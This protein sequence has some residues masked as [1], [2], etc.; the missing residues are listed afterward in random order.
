[1]KRILVICTHNSARSQMAEAW[2]RTYTKEL[3]LNAEISSAGTSKTFVKPNAIKVMEEVGIDMSR[4]SS[5][6]LDEL[7]DKQNFYLVI[8]VCDKAKELCPVFPYDCKR[9]HLAFE[10]PSGK[11]LVVWRKIRDE[12]ALFSRIVVE[13]LLQNQHLDEQS[14]KAAMAARQEGL[15]NRKR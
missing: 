9:L 7:E 10:D 13:R 8:T 12:I 1:M 11:P 15:R 6:S 4:H 5:K 3:G 2:L 14:I